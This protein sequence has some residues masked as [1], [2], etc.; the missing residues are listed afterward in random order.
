MTGTDLSDVQSRTLEYLRGCEHASSGRI[1]R[2]TGATVATLQALAA[3]G[4]IEPCRHASYR[5]TDA[6]RQS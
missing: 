3:R 6:G 5:I 4:L 2:T 1:F